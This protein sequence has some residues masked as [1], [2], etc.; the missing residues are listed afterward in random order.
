MVLGLQPGASPADI[1]KAYH[2][3]AL[4]H[5]PDVDKTPGAEERMKEINRAYEELTSPAPSPV[6]VFRG[7]VIII[8]TQTETPPT[9][10]AWGWGAGTGTMWPF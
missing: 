2:S 7:R 10:G 9:G 8:V 1:K 5:H 4:R 3:L 6:P